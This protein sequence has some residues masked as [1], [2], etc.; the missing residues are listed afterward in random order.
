MILKNIQQGMN[1][2]Q[3]Q[4]DWIPGIKSQP[5]LPGT[6]CV[7]SP[8]TPDVSKV[9][10]MSV[11]PFPR[12]CLLNW[13]TERSIHESLVVITLV[14]MPRTIGELFQ[15]A[16]SLSR[17]PNYIREWSH[18]SLLLSKQPWPSH[19][20]SLR[21]PI[22][23]YYKGSSLGPNLPQSNAE[24]SSKRGCENVLCMLPKKHIF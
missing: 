14:H 4:W 13:I 10:M 22:L 24:R 3:S 12:I 21:N 7:C 9:L 17:P 2:C 19:L 15:I 8:P 6:H 20:P 16:W 23:L 18:H 11:G 5:S 1:T